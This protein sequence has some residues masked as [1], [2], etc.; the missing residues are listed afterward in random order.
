MPAQLPL[1]TVHAQDS[2]QNWIDLIRA[3]TLQGSLSRDERAWFRR[4]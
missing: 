1:E 2:L 3:H 4:R